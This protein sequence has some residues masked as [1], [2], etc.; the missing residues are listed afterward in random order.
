MGKKVRVRCPTC[1][2][3]VWQSR[4]NKDFS[5]EFVLQESSGRGYRKI[6]HKYR[7]MRVPDSEGAKLFV[8][9]LAVKM[10][11]KAKQLVRM[12]GAD[13]VMEISL[14]MLGEDVADDLA[15]DEDVGG[16]DVEYV[17]EM[18]SHEVEVEFDDGVYEIEVPVLVE[19]DVKRSFLG[20]L[21]GGGGVGKVVDDMEAVPVLERVF[22]SVIAFANEPTTFFIKGLH[23]ALGA[24][25]ITT[26][27]VCGSY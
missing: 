18:V 9:M 14:Q 7:G 26:S 12:V 16:G 1:G 17:P 10:V 15:V 5:F 6:E 8:A 25:S 4:L 13:D 22:S 24:T 11:E 2:M 23:F 19:G 20:R 21:F 3:L 27:S